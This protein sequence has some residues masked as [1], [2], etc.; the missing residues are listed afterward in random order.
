VLGTTVA[1]AGLSSAA[2]GATGTLTVTYTDGSAQQI[3][4]AFSDWTLGAGAYQPLPGDTVAATT[5]YRNIDD[6]TSDQTTTYVYSFSGP[7]VVEGAGF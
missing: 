7:R 3:P 4:V 1:A 2:T 5:P 6:G